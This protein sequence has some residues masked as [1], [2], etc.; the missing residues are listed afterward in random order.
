MSEAPMPK[1]RLADAIAELRT[2]LSR[3]RR[4][5]EGQNI[6]FAARA[7]EVELAIEFGWSAEGKAGTPKWV[8]FLDL[9]I[10]GASSKK[11]L[12]KIKLTLELDGGGIISDPDGPAPV[13]SDD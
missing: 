12:H 1:I 2:E 6:R 11:A 4:E 13:W 7:I 3:A 10:K 9:G 8:P 5:G